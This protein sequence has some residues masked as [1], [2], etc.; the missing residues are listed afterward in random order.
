MFNSNSLFLSFDVESMGLYGEAFSFGYVLGDAKGQI[1]S[2]AY[3]FS[4]TS[5]IFAREADEMRGGHNIDWIEKNIVSVAG[6]PTGETASI[7]TTFWK[8]YTQLKSKYEFYVVADCP[9]P[10]ESNFLDNVIST[11]LVTTNR[12]NEVFNYSPYP[13]LDVCSMRA[14]VGLPINF[15]RLEDEY[16]IHH[17]LADAKQSYRG[18]IEVFETGLPYRQDA[19]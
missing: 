15:D 2:S 12:G 13:L 17:P 7:Y 19:K 18:L 1:I 4:E 8:H 9:V 6:K 11:H 16:P 14:A 10:V 5:L 3:V